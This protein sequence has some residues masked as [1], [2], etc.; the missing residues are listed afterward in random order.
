MVKHAFVSSYNCVTWSQY[1][2]MRDSL[3]R[4]LFEPQPALL[5]DASHSATRRI[6][7]SP[8]PLVAVTVRALWGFVDSLALRHSHWP[9]WSLWLLG[10]L[11]LWILKLSLFYA[12][13]W[14]CTCVP[15]TRAAA[16]N[17]PK[18]DLRS[19]LT[20]SR[21]DAIAATKIGNATA[22]DE[23]T[24]RKVTFEDVKIKKEK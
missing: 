11:C 16:V 17:L 18:H 3:R 7:L 15:K 24:Q 6:G 12:I 8:I 22:A 2:E 13:F 19:Q 9:Y 23:T 20:S 1:A 5:A 10:L 21:D 14:Y 4:E